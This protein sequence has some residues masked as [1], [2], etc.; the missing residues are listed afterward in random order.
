MFT[1]DDKFT[2]TEGPQGVLILYSSPCVRPSV[3]GVIFHYVRRSSP[4]IFPLA[5]PVEGNFIGM[6]NEVCK[7]VC[8]QWVRWPPREYMVYTFEKKNL[9]KLE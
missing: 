6:E 1:T 4:K 8:I 5:L 7:M 9:Y 3:G 2:I